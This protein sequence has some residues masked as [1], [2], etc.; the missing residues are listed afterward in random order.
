MSKII[1]SVLLAA[2]ALASAAFAAPAT[3]EF[4]QVSLDGEWMLAVVSPGESTGAELTPAPDFPEAAMRAARVPHNW[5]MDEFERARYRYPSDSVGF[6][7]KRFVAPE[8]SEGQRLTVWFDG[9]LYGAEAWLNGKRLGSH[10]GGFTGFGFDVTEFV[11]PGAE[12]V[13]DVKATKSGTPGH[14]FDCG[15]DWALS[16]IYRSVYLRKLPAVYI[17]KIKVE[18]YFDEAGE[19][20]ELRARVWARNSGAADGAA[21]ASFELFAPGGGAA[22]AEASAKIDVAA[23]ETVELT[24]SAK[25]ERPLRWSAE[26]P[27]LYTLRTAL[28]GG[29]SEP[30]AVET[31]V[32]FREVRTDG[33]LLLV[34]GAPVKLRGVVRREISAARG[35]AVSAEDAREDIRMMKRANINAVRTQ[36]RPPHPAFLELCD[37]MGMYVFVE[38]P[39]G[40][41]DFMLDRPEIVPMAEA[42][43]SETIERDWNHPSVIAWSLGDDNRLSDSH[44]KLLAF[45]KSLD[46]T[47]PLTMPGTGFHRDKLGEPL[48]EE[49]G[50]L[51]P[52]NPDAERFRLILADQVGRPGGRPV[53]AAE[54]LNA[55]GRRLDTAEMWNAVELYESSAGGFVSRWMDNGIIREAG[56]ERVYAHGEP[57]DVLADDTLFAHRR[58]DDGRIID[59]HGAAGEDGLVDSD[60]NPR[61]AYYEIRKI[62][63]PI[64]IDDGP[65]EFKPGQSGLELGI[66][67]NYYF[68]D[69][70]GARYYWKL[71][72]DFEA[73][74]A[75]AGA[76][77]PLA[78]RASGVQRFAVDFPGAVRRGAAYL[79]RISVYDI[80]G[81]LIDTH[82]VELKP[83]LPLHVEA[84]FEREYSLKW[85]PA[86]ARATVFAREGG[87]PVPYEATIK[88]SNEGNIIAVKKHNGTAEPGAPAQLVRFDEWWT[89]QRVMPRKGVLRV[90]AEVVA[91][92][93]GVKASGFM[94][95]ATPLQVRH[96]EDAI[97]VGNEDFNV[98]LY[99][100]TGM[101]GR[102]RVDGAVSDIEGPALNVWR[103]LLPV[104]TT[105]PSFRLYAETTLPALKGMRPEVEQLKVSS[106]A[107]E[108]VWLTAKV[109][110]HLPGGGGAGF[111]AVYDYDIDCNGVVAVKYRIT[112]EIG[113]AEL[114]EMGVSFAFP[115]EFDTL[116][117]AGVGPDAYPGSMPGTE[118]SMMQTVKR[119]SAHPG[120]GANMT[121]VRWAEAS[122]RDNSVRFELPFESA[123]HNARADKDGRRFILRVNPWAKRP[124]IANAD[125][126][127]SFRVFVR[128]GDMFEGSFAIKLLDAR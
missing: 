42:R 110:Y 25:V 7:R 21:T 67:N 91:P 48:P 15:D 81:A 128:N 55:L 66:R 46:P 49:A 117:V 121:A 59:A 43:V 35:K 101:I 82:Q 53:V 10:I 114:L 105:Q 120:F 27:S 13:L 124:Y 74:G 24:L 51:A 1:A 58:L 63:S 65:A 23:G 17:E 123:V 89:A 19:D 94:R 71:F 78:P 119:S 106:E 5:E 88:V 14:E 30:T 104:E 22:A 56:G 102:I 70:E 107:P 99:K 118:T 40:Y 86:N 72:E 11:V 16:G 44:P 93:G 57:L 20:A 8:M 84:S 50:I 112:P 9:V 125:P 90:D 2:A 76:F 115:P 97:S 109:Y 26:T 68:T 80:A 34:N 4:G 95:L 116:T 92:S 47:R 36:L 69:I 127:D 98:R 60:R 103:D 31:K 100:A 6:Y 54:F 73:I 108:K 61:A 45:A 122:G 41:G 29:D 126:P 111:R 37:E 87:E 3:V 39:F 32:G 62:Y 75:G 52:K 12:N 83:A 79:L 77:A 18:T 38:A 64:R 28:S 113:A 85:L 96:E 33:V